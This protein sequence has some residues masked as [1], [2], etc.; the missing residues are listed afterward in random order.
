MLNKIFIFIS[1]WSLSFAQTGMDIFYLFDISGSY[2]DDVLEKAVNFSEDFHDHISGSDQQEYLFP[3]KHMLSVIDEFS[4]KGDPCL[5]VIEATRKGAFIRTKKI[6]NDKFSSECLKTVLDSEPANNT[7]IYGGV[8]YA[9]NSLDFPKRRKALIVF[10]DFKD[11]PAQRMQNII[12]SIDLKDIAV[13]LI[14][15][16]TDI[17]KGGAQSK[18]LSKEFKKFAQ[19]RNALDVK[20][21]SLNS[22]LYDSSALREFSNTL[23]KVS[24]N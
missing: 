24:K 15:S 1:L 13:F 14:W 22:M 6:K 21:Y 2:H 3:Q 8:L 5:N 7:D 10:S 9:Q 23:K 16:D 4:L 12:D 20:V 11:Y 17:K 19:E 18:K